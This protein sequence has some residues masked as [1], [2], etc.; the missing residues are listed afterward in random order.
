MSK[1]LIALFTLYCHFST[2][3]RSKCKRRDTEGRFFA[4]GAF[5]FCEK[6]KKTRARAFAV[7][8]SSVFC[9][10]YIKLVEY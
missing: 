1:R 8:L 7:R 4:A 10:N 2:N 6:R 5:C 9:G 3:D